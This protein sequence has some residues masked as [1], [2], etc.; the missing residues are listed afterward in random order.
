M[1]A[2]EWWDDWCCVDLSGRGRWRWCSPDRP[3]PFAQVL[4]LRGKYGPANDISRGLLWNRTLTKL[5]IHGLNSDPAESRD[6]LCRAISQ[7]PTLREVELKNVYTVTPQLM[8]LLVQTPCLKSLRLPGCNVFTRD[9]SAPPEVCCIV[10]L[11][12]GLWRADQYFYQGVGEWVRT[13]WHAVCT[14]LARR[15]VAGQ[16]LA[17]LDLASNAFSPQQVAQK[18][19]CSLPAVDELNL[20][21]CAMGT[22]VWALF[23]IVSFFSAAFYLERTSFTMQCTESTYNTIN[24]A[25]TSPSS[26]QAQQTT[27]QRPHHPQHK[28][29]KT[30]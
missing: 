30:Q 1:G 7:H 19:L 22:P 17:V 2:L 26:T 12:V 20:G 27:A 25:T 24:D 29:S 4:F 18:I 8:A 15:R 11:G 16:P 6:E 28:R 21:R 9:A 5:C 14:T 3:V 13:G 23:L 10:E